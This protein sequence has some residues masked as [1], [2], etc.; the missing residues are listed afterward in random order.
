MKKQRDCE[1][2]IYGYVAQLES[3]VLCL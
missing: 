1:F 2:M 3:V